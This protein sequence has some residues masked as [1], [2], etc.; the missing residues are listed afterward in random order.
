[1][2][3]KNHK[4]CNKIIEDRLENEEENELNIDNETNLIQ[5][6]PVWDIIF[7]MFLLCSSS[8]VLFIPRMFSVITEVDKNFLYFQKLFGRVW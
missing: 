6:P 4:Q 3:K 7:P 8:N 5:F 1:M 2:V